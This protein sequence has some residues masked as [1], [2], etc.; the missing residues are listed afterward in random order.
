MAG[1]Y[2]LVRH[3]IYLGVLIAC[4]GTTIAV[5]KVQSLVWLLNIVTFRQKLKIEEVRCF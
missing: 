5:A 1:P 3:P 4:I 2:S